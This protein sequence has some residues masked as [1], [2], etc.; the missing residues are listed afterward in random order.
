MHE[1]GVTTVE[2]VE[3]VPAAGAVT[4][5]T[6]GATNDLGPRTSAIVLASHLLVDHDGGVP[7]AAAKLLAGGTYPQARSSHRSATLQ[8]SISPTLT[9]AGATLAEAAAS[10]DPSG[11][12]A[13]SMTNLVESVSSKPVSIVDE[14]AIGVDRRGDGLVTQTGR[15]RMNGHIPS[16]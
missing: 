9:S 10:A 6:L 7:V 3:T 5:L 2:R 16:K 11:R 13:H 12:L 4:G 8:A 14:M 1:L 15:Y